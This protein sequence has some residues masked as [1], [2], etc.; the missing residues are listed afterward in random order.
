MS[1]TNLQQGAL[2]TRDTYMALMELKKLVDGAAEKIRI[3]E[4]ETVAVAIGHRQGDDPLKT[5]QDVAE[6]LQ[7][8]NFEAAVALAREKTLGAITWHLTLHEEEK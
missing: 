4:R 3:A 2:I 7:S 6:T 8:G 1:F 5:L